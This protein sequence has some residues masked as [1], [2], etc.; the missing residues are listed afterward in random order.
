MTT[1]VPPI[2]FDYAA[3]VARY[4]EFAAI[5]PELAQ[6]YFDEA[7]DYCPNATCNP[8]FQAI[9][10]NGTTPVPLLGRLLN[11][12]TAHIAW[13]SA[14]RDANGNPSSTGQVSSPLVGRI[15]SAAEGSVNVA[16]ELNSSGS[17]SEA[18]FTQTKYGFAY[19]Q[20]TAQFRTAIYMA[21]PTIVVD[22]IFP[23]VPFRGFYRR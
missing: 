14:P 19:W 20:A 21:N 17:P 6:A 11:M 1:T 18:W 23:Y 4:P 12:L 15:N 9:V 2:I 5:S 10:Y 22:S 8:A 13:L 16:I 7:G 3:W